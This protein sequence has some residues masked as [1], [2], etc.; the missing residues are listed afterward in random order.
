LTRKAM[1]QL[2]QQILEGAHTLPDKKQREVLNF[3]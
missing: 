1:I 2:E 3:I